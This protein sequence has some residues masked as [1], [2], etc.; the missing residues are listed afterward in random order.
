MGDEKPKRKGRIFLIVALGICSAASMI[1]AS[2]FQPQLWAETEPGLLSP[3]VTSPDT[4][5]DPGD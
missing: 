1:A 2:Q 3:A 4:P 5:H